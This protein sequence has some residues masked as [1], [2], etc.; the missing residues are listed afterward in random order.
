VGKAQS[1]TGELIDV[2]RLERTSINTDVA[3]SKVVG[4]DENDV[5]LGGLFRRMRC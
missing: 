1:L 5:R 3:E 2:R 4:E